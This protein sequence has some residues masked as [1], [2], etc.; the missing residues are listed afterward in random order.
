MNI[1]EAKSLLA[2]NGIH[3][4]NKGESL[5]DALDHVQNGSLRKGYK[6]KRD[7]GALMTENQ[8]IQH[9]NGVAFSKMVTPKEY[10]SDEVEDIDDITD[11]NNY[12]E[13]KTKRGIATGCYYCGTSIRIDSGDSDEDYDV[14]EPEIHC[15]DCMNNAIANLAM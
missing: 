9:E 12:R 10:V 2:Q 15:D 11:S 3:Q 4:L 13:D 6:F 7:D 1:S 8:I 5:A 14:H